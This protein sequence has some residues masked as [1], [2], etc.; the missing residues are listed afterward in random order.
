MLVETLPS[1]IQYNYDKLFEYLKKKKISIYALEE[2]HGITR[3]ILG[4]LRK[5]YNTSIDTLAQIADVAGIEDISEMVEF[6][7]VERRKARSFSIFFEKTLK[8]LHLSEKD[9]IEAYGISNDLLQ[10][11]KEDDPS[12]TIEEIRDIAN[13]LN[14]DTI[15][16]YI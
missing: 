8:E 4:R 5:G 14:I 1:M 6:R 10:R 7:K 11:M 16:I 2:K 9:L 13:R 15:Y 3:G 12:V